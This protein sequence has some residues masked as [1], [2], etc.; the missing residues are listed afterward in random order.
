MTRRSWRRL[1]AQMAAVFLATLAP[2]TASAWAEGSHVYMA[3]HSD[4]ASGQVDANELC[5]RLYGSVAVDLFAYDFTIEG[6]TL[7]AVLHDPTMA[8]P[9]LPYALATG[10]AERAFA[11]GLASHNQ[12]WGT[13]ATAH[14]DGIT[15]GNRD[16]YVIAKARQLAAIPQFG[17]PVLQLVGDEETLL[18]VSHI[19]VEYAIDLVVARIDPAI[20]ADLVTAALACQPAAGADLLVKGWVPVFSNWMPPEVA[21]RKIRE[22]DAAQR[23]WAAKYGIALQQPNAQQLVAGAVAEVATEFLRVPT[24]YLPWLTALIDQALSA[25]QGLVAGDVQAELDATIGRVNAALS[26][27]KIRP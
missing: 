16:G 19:L 6:Q 22:Q 26:I 23:L 21:E 11:Y 18:L 14:V 3:K 8:L 13:D 27:Q 20:G 10:D 7:H 15:E 5:N 24:E 2:I 17:E 25:G 12:A 1:A 4:K 9:A